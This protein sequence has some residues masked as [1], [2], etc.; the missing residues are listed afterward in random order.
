MDC[1][2]FER[3]YFSIKTI[4]DSC[5]VFFCCLCSF[6]FTRG[7]FLFFFFIFFFFIFFF[8]FFFFY[9]FFLNLYPSFTFS[10]NPS[11]IFNLLS[12]PIPNRMAFLSPPPG[13]KKEMHQELLQNGNHLTSKNQKK[14]PLSPLLFLKKKENTP[15]SPPL[16]LLLFLKKK[17]NI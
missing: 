8:Y 15:L 6:C 4:W 16:F 17:K 10:F 13:E 12:S 11:Q 3:S 14:T 2:I 9:F 5:Y 1:R 7:F